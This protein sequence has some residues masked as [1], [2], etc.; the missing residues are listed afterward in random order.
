LTEELAGSA[1]KA[2]S[3]S[4]KVSGL[5][6]AG[7]PQQFSPTAHPVANHTLA[8]G[9][10]VAVLEVPGRISLPSDMARVV[11]METFLWSGLRLDMRRGF[12][13]ERDHVLGP[14]PG[15]E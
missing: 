8:F 13:H 4:F 12:G 14:W 1:I 15:E 10:I 5:Y 9:V 2:L 3:Q 6:F 11:R 7:E